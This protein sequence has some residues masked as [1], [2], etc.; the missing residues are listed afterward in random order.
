[1]ELRRFKGILKDFIIANE[2]GSTRNGFYHKST[3]FYK[4][5]KQLEHKCDYLNR[6]WEVYTFQTSMLCA[7][8]DKIEQLKDKIKDQYKKDN[9][10]KRITASKQ[11]ELEKI[12]KQ[13]QLLKKYYKL[14]EDVRLRRA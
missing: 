5:I 14:Y 13:D 2:A 11:N 9:N 6:T 3:L 4:G 10:I 12:Y 7:I 1:M 8:D